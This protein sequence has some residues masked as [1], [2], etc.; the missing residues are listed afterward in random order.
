MAANKKRKTSVKTSTNK[1]PDARPVKKPQIKAETKPT[2][3]KKNDNTK[4]LIIAAAAIILIGIFWVGP[5]L[6]NNENYDD[7]NLPSYTYTNAPTLKAYEYAIENPEVIEKIPCYCGCEGLGHTSLLNCYISNDGVYSSHASNCDICVGEVIRIKELYESGM[8]ISDIKEIIDKEYSQYGEGNGGVPITEDFNINLKD[9]VA[10]SQPV[11]TPFQAEDYTTIELSPNFRGLT[12]GLNMTPRGVIWA[13][14]INMKLASGT[15]IEEYASEM[16]QPAGFYGVPLAA[17]YAADY[18]STSWIELHD[19]GIT[20][21]AIQP[22]SSEG[23]SN[24]IATRPFIYGHTINVEKTRQLMADPSSMDSAY[25]D[26]QIVLEGIDVNNTIMS[27]VS[28]SPNQY[29]DIFYSGLSDAGNGLMKREMVY[30]L[31]LGGGASLR[32]QYEA[33]AANSLANGFTSYDVVQ[34]NN[35]L[36]VTVIGTLDKVLNEAIK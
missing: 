9:I 26:F 12:D 18:S 25:L 15:L 17:M 22:V 19:I 27:A 33:R 7:L 2:Q 4:L 8:Y 36:K 6:I 3:K 29:A 11:P 23:K 28:N 30:H 32:S 31:N 16:V 14:F 21:Q 5:K 13:Q 20:N 1:P 10:S 35:I 24:V 34:N